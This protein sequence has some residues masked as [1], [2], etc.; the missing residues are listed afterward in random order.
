MEKYY[1]GAENKTHRPVWFS[2]KEE[3]FSEKSCPIKWPWSMAGF[4]CNGL[5]GFKSGKNVGEFNRSKE[6]V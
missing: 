3:W 2:N 6:K 4:S 5:M 1:E